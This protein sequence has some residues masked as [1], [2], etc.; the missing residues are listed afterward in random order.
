MFK[1]DCNCKKKNEYTKKYYNNNNKCKKV[2]F[3][4]FI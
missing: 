3:I 4:K 2:L 1:K